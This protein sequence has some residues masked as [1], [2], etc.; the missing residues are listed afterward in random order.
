M[1]KFFIT[2]KYF[3]SK[4]VSYADAENVIFTVLKSSDDQDEK[5]GAETEMFYMKKSYKYLHENTIWD[6]SMHGSIG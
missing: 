4:F 5:L 1:V 2:K 6:Y 3:S